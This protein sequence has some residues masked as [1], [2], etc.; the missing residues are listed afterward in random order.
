MSH[1][2]RISRALR[3]DVFRSASLPIWAGLSVVLGAAIIARVHFDIPWQHMMGDPAVITHSPFYFGFVSN[4]GALLWAATASIFLF[5]FHV[6]R[7]SGGDAECGRFLL[8][9]GLFVAIL[10]IDDFFMLHDQV[11][12]DYLSVSQSLVVAAYAVIALL[13][14][15]RFTPV[16]A[17]TAYPVLVAAMGMLAASAALDQFQD[18]FSY[19]FVGRGFWEDAAKL[20]GIGTWLSYAIHTAAAALREE[21]AGLRSPVGQRGDNALQA[22]PSG[23]STT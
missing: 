7:S 19:A 20:A 5:A 6:H 22:A 14:V 1:R 4:V 13:Y 10:G 18:R 23:L 9:S 2:E 16:I 8:Y 3:L 12:P 11:F 21:R 17:R 15:W